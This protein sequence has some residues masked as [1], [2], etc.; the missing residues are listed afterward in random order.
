MEPPRRS[1]RYLG[2]RFGKIKGAP[3]KPPKEKK[4][5]TETERK[6]KIKHYRHLKGQ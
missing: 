5:K 3:G 4:H 6:K 2:R 1:R